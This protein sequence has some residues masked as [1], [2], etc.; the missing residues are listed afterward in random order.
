VSIIGNR[1]PRNGSVTASPIN[2]K[3]NTTEVVLRVDGFEDPDGDYPVMYRWY[4]LMVGNAIKMTDLTEH[5]IYRTTFPGGGIT[6]TCEACDT[7]GDC[8]TVSASVY[9]ETLKPYEARPLLSKDMTLVATDRVPV[10][11]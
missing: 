1:K 10:E 3:A 6:I 11:I 5:P 7:L 4:Y 2:G 8:T 9:M